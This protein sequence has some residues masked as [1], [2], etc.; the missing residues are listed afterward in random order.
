MERKCKIPGQGIVFNPRTA[1][2]DVYGPEVVIRDGR[3]EPIFTADS[4]AG[5]VT[6][7]REV[8]GWR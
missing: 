2:W 4:F 1:K 8:E 5:A 7:A 3:R 6:Y